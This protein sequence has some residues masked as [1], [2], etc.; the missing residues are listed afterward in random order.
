MATEMI[1]GKHVLRFT[2]PFFYDGKPI[3]NSV[4]QGYQTG[5][6]RLTINTLLKGL[7][8]L[9]CRDDLDSN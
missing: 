8:Y 7:V 1:T 9:L 3:I 4:I 6:M 5:K 2:S